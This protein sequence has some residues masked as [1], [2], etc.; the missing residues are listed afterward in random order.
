MVQHHNFHPTCTSG[1]ARIAS[2]L[3]VSMPVFCMPSQQAH[4]LTAGSQVTNI[5]LPKVRSLDPGELAARHAAVVAFQQRRIAVVAVPVAAVS[6]ARAKPAA[7]AVS[8]RRIVC[9]LRPVCSRKS[10]IKRAGW[11]GPA[12]SIRRSTNPA[13]SGI[14]IITTEPSHQPSP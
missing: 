14:G 3:R 11:L 2:R 6:A 7:T 9:A 8:H 5:P 1:I 12:D 10:T 13:P 4:N